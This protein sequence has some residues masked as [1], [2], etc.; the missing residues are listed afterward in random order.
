MRAS[1]STE[2]ETTPCS[3]RESS[4]REMPARRASSPPEAPLAMRRARIWVPMREADSLRVG[5]GGAGRGS[6][7]D[8]G[9]LKG[10]AVGK[11]EAIRLVM[12]LLL[13]GALARANWAA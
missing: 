11:G 3:M 13:P 9:S 1:V 8:G 2:G 5:F 12:P 4:E 6:A 7:R 10:L